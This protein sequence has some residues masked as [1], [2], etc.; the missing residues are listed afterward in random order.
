MIATYSFYFAQPWWLLGLL[1]LIPIVLMGLRSLKAL[2]RIRRSLAIILRMLVLIIISVLLARPMLGEKSEKLTLI[3][4]LDRSQSIP[5]GLQKASISFLSEAIETR[6]PTDQLAV[7]DV[8]EVAAISKLPSY[9]D[10]IRQ[11]NT[12]LTGRQSRLSAGIQMAMAIA[13]PDS[14][15]R[16]LLISDGNETEGNLTEAAKIAAANNIPVD[17]LPLRY[18]YDR[19]VVFKRLVAPSRARSAQSI[20]LRF[21]L[22]STANS[23]GRVLLNLNGK[24]VDLDPDSSDVAV[25]IELK[26]GTN[27]KTISLPVGTSGMHEFEAFFVPDDPDQDGILR[28]NRAGAMTF[29]TGPG[30]VLVVDTDGSTGSAIIR[31]LQEANIDVRYCGADEFPPNLTR[32]LDT[33]AIV[34]VNTDNSNFTYNQQEMLCRYVEDLGG[35]LIMVGGPDSFGAGGWIGSPLAEILP[36]DLDPPQ[37]KQLPKGALVLIMHACEMPRGNYWGKTVAIAAV[38]SLSRLD[39]VGILDYGWNAGDSNWVFPL[40]P[41]GDKKQVISAIKQMQMGDMPDF[42]APMQAAYNKLKDCDAVQKHM[43]IISDGDPS[44]PSPQLLNQL[45]QAEITCSG[46]AVFP[47]SSADVQSLLRI[48]KVTGGRFYNVKDPSSLPQI[49]IKEAKIV[50]RPLII[51]ETFSPRVTFGLS[52]I[53]KGIPSS[54]PKLDGYVLTGPKGGLTQM[55]LSSPKGDPILATGQAGL[56]RCVAFTSS[57]DS[58]WASS[59]VQWSGFRRF[60][61]QTIRWASKSSHPGDC[62]IF[63]DVRGRNVTVSVEAVDASGN[64][65]QF[66]DI[67]GQVIDPEMTTRELPLSQVGPG[68]YRA[69][70]QAPTPGSYLVNLRYKKLGEKGKT[71]IVQSAITVPYGVEFRDLSDNAA[72]LREVAHVTG[73]RVLKPDPTQADLF[74]KTGV[75]FPETA[76]PLT[77]PLI[78][79]WLVV[80]LLDVAVRR[81]AL[82][83]R[84]VAKRVSSLIAGIRPVISGSTTLDRLKFRRAQLRKHLTAGTKTDHASKRFEAGEGAS[85]NMP[86]PEVSQQ[87]ETPS[88]KPAQK[89][90]D[91]EAHDE[92]DTS[93]LQQLLKVKRMHS[94]RFENNSKQSGEK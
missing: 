46:V 12:S 52:E 80:F 85:K 57:A 54:L 78:L 26:P 30:H 81:I 73:G 74:A 13:P 21:V 82:D 71:G 19:E 32:L 2:S 28:N 76:I 43:I 39:L 67:A 61:E 45:K 38:K 79:I 77:K 23:R 48:A 20:T 16:I 29:V 55:I 86:L 4:I 83:V 89:P 60:W 63:S 49:F 22:S 25:A 90:T 7:I 9:D 8:S 44:P 27:V 37:K 47:H 33:D 6:K 17:V 3:A 59:W 88:D 87:T 50:R 84:A 42:H 65:V 1:L 34:L 10:T 68:M 69:E 14:A 91:K 62:E 31:S 58:R 92:K 51:E 41:A 53:V 66:T 93:H 35:G 18:S 56:G 5:Q 40:A 70:F 11:R 94:K 75:K 15:T 72:L 36:V 24:P 64:F